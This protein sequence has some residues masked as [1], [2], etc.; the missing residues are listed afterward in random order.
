[1]K[2]N[3]LKPHYGDYL[4]SS[5]FILVGQRRILI[6]KMVK[7]NNNLQHLFLNIQGKK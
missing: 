6:K 4:H 7:E 1:M 2:K 5:F 3:Y